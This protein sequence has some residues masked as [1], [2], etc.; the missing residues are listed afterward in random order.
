MKPSDANPGKVASITLVLSALALGLAACDSSDQASEAPAEPPSVAVAAASMQDIRRSFE[1][2]GEVKAV[3]EVDMIA[4]VSG[5][6]DDKNVEDGARVEKGDLLFTIEK[7]PYQAALLSAKA[8]VADAKAEAALKAADL[9]RDQD[10]YEKGHVSKAKLDATMAAKEKADAGVEA[11]EASLTQ[12]EL[13]LSYTDMQAPFEGQIG[14]TAFSIGDV[15]GPSSGSIATLVRLSPV[16][17]SFSISEKDLLGSVGKGGLDPETLKSLEDVPTVS[18]VLPTGETYKDTGSI[19]FVDNKVDPRTGT[20]SMRAQFEND[21][22][23]LIAGTFVTVVL[24]QSETVRAL[25]V[26]QAAIQRDQKG[27]F[28]LAVNSEEM[29]E[30]RHVELGDP[31]DDGFEV[32][33]GLQEGER[34]I[35]Q[36]LQKVRPGVPVN[37]V[38]GNNPGE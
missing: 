25:T 34:V 27:P 35:V 16:Y 20:I 26:P 12:A 6:L 29:V 3:D 5:F 14:R 30:Q 1:F 37:A 24:S 28:V 19:V 38:L 21:D 33:S 23:V 2:I 15:V 18:V 36:G 32:K 22:I 10:L 8:D 11:S 9:L 4:R 17:V 13:D 7:A 31:T